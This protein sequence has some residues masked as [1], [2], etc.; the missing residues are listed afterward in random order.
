MKLYIVIFIDIQLFFRQPLIR[1][2]ERLNELVKMRNSY[3]NQVED[4]TIL[5]LKRCDCRFW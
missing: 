5:W 1:F 3:N 4:F 2:N